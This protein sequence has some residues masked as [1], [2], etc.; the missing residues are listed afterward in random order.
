MKPDQIER[1]LNSVGKGCFVTYY[2]MFA[3]ESIEDREIHEALKK[4]FGYTENSCR[5]KTSH[6]RSIIRTGNARRAMEI[7]SESE[8]EKVL[9]ALALRYLEA[10]A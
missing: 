7:I 6:A 3:D 5:L 10:L 1:E 9:R 4:D 2:Q 8:S